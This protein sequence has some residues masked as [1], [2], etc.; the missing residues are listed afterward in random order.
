[1]RDLQD[2]KKGIDENDDGETFLLDGI[3]LEDKDD[4]KNKEIK[5]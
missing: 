5:D 4:L 2:L 1:M 3:K